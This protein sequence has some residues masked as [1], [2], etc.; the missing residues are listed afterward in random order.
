MQ[1]TSTMNVIPPPG[2]IY[3]GAPPRVTRVKLFRT[4]RVSFTGF[5]V[6]PERSEPPAP[7][8]KRTVVKAGSQFSLIR[9]TDSVNCDGSSFSTGC[10]SSFSSKYANCSPVVL[11]IN[12]RRCGQAIP[13]L[14]G[15]RIVNGSEILVPPQPLPG[16]AT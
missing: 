14:N 11:T 10:K 9:C 15:F 1:E 16:F 13:G 2:Q 8:I 4:E 5:S 7:P 12:S 3:T 6:T